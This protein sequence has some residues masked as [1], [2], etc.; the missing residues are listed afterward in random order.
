VITPPGDAHAL[1]M[2]VVTLLRRPDLAWSLGRR[3]HGRLGRIFNEAACLSGY[4]ELLG[5]AAL[6]AATPP[7]FAV[8]EAIAA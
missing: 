3:G 5:N 7:R 2:G 4:R 1:A 8:Q 6:P